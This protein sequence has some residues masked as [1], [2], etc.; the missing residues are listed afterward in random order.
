MLE[1]MKTIWRGWKRFAHGLI[2]GQSWFL[3]ALVYVFA[4]GPVSV[5]IRLSPRRRLDRAPPSP[6]ATTYALPIRFEPQDARR[7]QRPW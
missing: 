5:Y 6:G 7:A 1:L 3:M 4:M 2:A